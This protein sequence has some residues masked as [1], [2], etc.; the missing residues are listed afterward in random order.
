MDW[1]RFLPKAWCVR[2]LKDISFG[3]RWFLAPHT[4]LALSMSRPHGGPVFPAVEILELTSRNLS[5]LVMSTSVRELHWR[6]ESYMGNSNNLWTLCR[7]ITDRMPLI[8]ALE[9]QYDDALAIGSPVA[10]LCSML[11][12]LTTITL[13]VYGLTEDIICAL[14]GLPSLQRVVMSMN[15]TGPG[16]V[17]VYDTDAIK[18]FDPSHMH[19]AQHGFP[20]LRTLS[21]S[22]PSVDAATNL[23]KH[24]VFHQSE[25]K[26]VL[27][28]VPFAIGVRSTSVANMF[29]ELGHI[30][31]PLQELKLWLTPD[32]TQSTSR[33]RQMDRLGPSEF[34]NIGH[35]IQLTRLEVYHAMPLNFTNA[36]VGSLVAGLPLIE[37]LILNPH[38][39]VP[40]TTRLSFTVLSVLAQKCPKIQELGIFVDGLLP[41]EPPPDIGR[42][43]DLSLLRL[44]R[45]MLPSI[46]QS[47]IRNDVARYLASIL[48]SETVVKTMDA[49]Y[50]WD[51]VDYHWSPGA[52]HLTNVTIS[53]VN[54][55]VCRLREIMAIARAVRE[56]RKVMQQRLDSVSQRLQI[57]KD[58]ANKHEKDDV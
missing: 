33:I 8:T 50:R 25:I 36:E 3:G 45:S 57:A 44:G 30:L 58:L 2:S 38:P 21:F 17:R 54:M 49:E 32:G 52:T 42:L 35:F 43:C 20:Q 55:H 11:T 14:S 7:S 4:E 1:R 5:K 48:P 34:Q 23:L 9:L 26:D 13:P 24:G 27:I 40:R 46:S 56:E 10:F 39:S 6:I 41:L 22:A 12:S 16:H 28:R 15:P 37:A 29:E 18:R 19:L 53:T 47:D 51:V 31:S